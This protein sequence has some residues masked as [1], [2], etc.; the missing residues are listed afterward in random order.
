MSAADGTSESDKFKLRLSLR[1]REKLLVKLRSQ[2]SSHLKPT[3]GV[4]G[5]RNPWLLIPIA[6]VGPLLSA[7]EKAQS[8]P[9]A[10]TF[11]NKCAL[12]HGADGSGNTPLGKQLHVGDLRSKD[13]HKMSDTELHRVVHD[14]RA[15]MPPFSEQLSSEEIDQVIKYVR[16]LGKASKR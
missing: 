6:F 9:G 1:R 11:K 5:T 12:C 15:N 14:G 7:H 16:L 8:I 3:R 4:L 2:K 10:D 13:V